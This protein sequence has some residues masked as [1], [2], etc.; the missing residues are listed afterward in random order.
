MLKNGRLVALAFACGLFATLAAPAA[1][2]MTPLM[3]LDCT[4]SNFPNCGWGAWGIGQGNATQTLRPG[5]GPQGQDA[6]EFTILAGGPRQFYMGWSGGSGGAVE[7]NA[8]RYYRFRIFAPGP[9]GQIRG[10]VQG[11]ESKFIIHADG[12]DN[13]S[14]VICG[15]RDNG[16][17]PDTL[18]FECMRNVDGQQHGTVKQALTLGVWHSIQVEARSGSNGVIR[19]WIDNNNYSSP[20][21]TSQH[22]AGSPFSLGTMNWNNFAI[23]FYQGVT[24]TLS[25][26][27]VA[28]RLADDAEFDDQFDPTWHEGASSSTP[29]SQ[30]TGVRVISSS[31]DWLTAGVVLSLL[32]RRRL[33]RAA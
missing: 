22:S 2:Q 12:A 23:G 31:M 5:Q 27:V 15:L 9:T 28:F 16:M 19:V 17:T 33:R 6:V 3:R 11:L 24:T 14:R 18:A 4:A 1:A 21:A 20:T 8:V 30:V 25:S 26:P 29:P 32:A 7:A 10:Y 13:G